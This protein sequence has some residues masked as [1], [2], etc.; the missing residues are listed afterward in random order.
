MPITPFGYTC[1]RL[2]LH[3]KAWRIYACGGANG[4]GEEGE[5]GREGAPERRVGGKYG[6]KRT[7]ERGDTCRYVTSL[8]ISGRTESVFRR[9]VIELVTYLRSLVL[10]IAPGVTRSV[11]NIKTDEG[12][13]RIRRRPRSIDAK[14]SVVAYSTLL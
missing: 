7:L 3:G 11:A 13:A 14:E 4:R 6:G 8:T 2:Y 1:T 10:D 12:Y 5:G 9:S